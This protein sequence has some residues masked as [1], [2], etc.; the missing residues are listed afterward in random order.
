MSANPANVNP[1]TSPITQEALPDDTI[2]PLIAEGREAFRRDLPDLL[3]RCPGKWVAYSG[4]RQ[5]GIGGTKTR[6]Y[7][8]CLSRG[9]KRGEF[10][11]LTV[12]PEY[13]DEVDLPLDV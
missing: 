4:S 10:I 2:P 3:K 11:V 13:D 7:Q 12:E 8:E 5:L 1:P 9:L 6:L